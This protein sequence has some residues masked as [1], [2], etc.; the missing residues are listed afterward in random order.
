MAALRSSKLAP[1]TPDGVLATELD[2]RRAGLLDGAQQHRLK[3]RRAID[4]DPVGLAAAPCSGDSVTL[5]IILY[6][7]TRIRVAT[8][9]AVRRGRRDGEELTA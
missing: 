2:D 7:L 1:G 6:C 3:V 8:P 9:V 5:F 4:Q